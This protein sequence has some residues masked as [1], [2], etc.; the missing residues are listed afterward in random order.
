MGAQMHL[1][2]CWPW[3][4]SISCVPN[5]IYKNNITYLLFHVY[6]GFHFINS[7]EK[8]KICDA[9]PVWLKV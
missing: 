2:A 8:S 1:G 6:I 9:I 7:S 3:S 5:D 4:V